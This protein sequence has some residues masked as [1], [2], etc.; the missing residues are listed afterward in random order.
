MTD[1]NYQTHRG[2]SAIHR[3]ICDWAWPGLDC[4]MCYGFDRSE[5]RCWCGDN[6]Y[7]NPRHT[8][9]RWNLFWRWIWERRS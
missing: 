5:G 1:R 7:G 8:P 2:T 9:S 4:E 6:G 3:V